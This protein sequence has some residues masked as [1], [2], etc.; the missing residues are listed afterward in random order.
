MRILQVNK[1]LHRRGGAEAYMIGVADLQR[2][3]GHDVAF[4]GMRHPDDEVHEYQA[5]FPEYIDFEAPSGLR[6]RVSAAARMLWS[7]S[8][9]RGM[10]QVLDDFRPDVVHVHNIYHQLSPSILAPV[11]RRG[12]PVVMTV[13]DYKLVCPTFQLLA[14][15]TICEACLPRRFHQ[16]LRVRCRQDSI[17]ASGMM[18]AEL[19]LHTAMR[20]YGPIDRYLCPS[21]FMADVL[22]RGKIDPDRLHVLR[23]FVPFVSAQEWSKP[24]PGGPIVFV[25]RLAPEKGLDVAIRAVALTRSEVH[26]VVAGDGPDAA[27]S[28]ELADRCAPGRVTF[29]GRL[30]G[31]EVASLLRGSTAVVVPSLWLE[32]QPLAVLEAYAAGVPVIATPL[33]GLAEI[34]EH[35]R[36]G[37]VVPPND[38]ASLAAAMESLVIDSESALRM[39]RHASD[40]VTSEHAPDRHLHELLAHYRAAGVSVA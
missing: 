26:L 22:R 35:N 37:L 7:T 38:P 20:A 8:A 11:R 21:Q 13:H 6:P 9:S 4:F 33:G 29:L 30:T 31:S 24:E 15:G 25:G 19:S 27:A 14:N 18:A 28:R 3:A 16:A 39:G 36:T 1:F 32:N 23:N 5:H 34:V 12:I 10:A 40:Y 17:V 2:D